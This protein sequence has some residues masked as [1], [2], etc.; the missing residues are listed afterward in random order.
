M[1]V[2]D[3]ENSEFEKLA[4][5]VARGFEAVDERLDSLREDID[6]RF[7]AV[8][9][10]LQS[11]RENGERLEA[12]MDAGFKSLREDIDALAA[13]HFPASAQIELRRRVERLEDRAGLPHALQP[14]S[15]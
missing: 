11:V 8:H 5:M 12:K 15:A 9:A 3:F 7:A 2:P 1:T 10:D 6:Q 13:D 4:G 14:A